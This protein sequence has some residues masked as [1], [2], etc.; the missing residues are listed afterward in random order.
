MHYATRHACSTPSVKRA[1]AA[2]GLAAL[3]AAHAAMGD[4]GKS[5]AAPLLN[6]PPSLLN[7]TTTEVAVAHGIAPSAAVGLAALHQSDISIALRSALHV[8]ATC[9]RRCPAK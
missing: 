9:P 1:E 7:L 2:E 8:A 5:A 3:A 6:L 4:A